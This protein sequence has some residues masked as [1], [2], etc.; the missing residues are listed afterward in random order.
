MNN[1]TIVVVLL[2]IN[3]LSTNWLFGQDC[4]LLSTML[5]TFGNDK[6][7]YFQ[8]YDSSEQF[9]YQAYINNSVMT[10]I[11][12]KLSKYFPEEVSDSLIK[13]CM[14]DTSRYLTWTGCAIK[15]IKIISKKKTKKIISR[16]VKN[17]NRKHCQ[18]SFESSA[19]YYVTSPIIYK[20]FAI[21]Q[22]KAYIH[23]SF[24]RFRLRL[25][26]YVNGEWMTMEE[27]YGGVS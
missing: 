26:R 22:C 23:P 3:C 8:V 25:F 16:N 2:I 9:Y 10:G 5:M 14:K 6:R 27:L 11:K 7:D 13:N 24:F 20:D 21:M 18:K 15:K 17:K 19:I 1:Q 4:K 12:E